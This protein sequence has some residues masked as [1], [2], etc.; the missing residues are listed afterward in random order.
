MNM[1]PAG[2]PG[3]MVVVVVVLGMWALFREFFMAGL[4]LMISIALV[5]AL[6]IRDWRVRHPRDT[7]LLHLDSEPVDRKTTE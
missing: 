6:V 1:S 3:L 5:A 7:N 2:L 4:A